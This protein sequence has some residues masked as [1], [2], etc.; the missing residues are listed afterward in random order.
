MKSPLFGVSAA[1]PMTFAGEEALLSVVAFAATCIPARR[2]T[3]AI[4]P[5]PCAMNRDGGSGAVRVAM[6]RVAQN[7][8]AP[9]APFNRAN[10]PP[11]RV[12]SQH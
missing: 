12:C 4:R 1:D 7:L 5:T 10:A 3:R 11:C 8:P 2:A 9:V 6:N